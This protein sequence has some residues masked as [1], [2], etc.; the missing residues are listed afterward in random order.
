MALNNN[1]LGLGESKFVFENKPPINFGRTNEDTLILDWL[2]DHA[3]FIMFINDHGSDE[4]LK[5]VGK[6]SLRELVAGRMFDSRKESIVTIGRKI[7]AQGHN[8]IK[9]DDGTK[10]Y[11]DPTELER[12]I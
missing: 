9:L 12:N 10:I 8:W 4:S 11:L 1:F 5:V 7:I 2:S 6:N 3:T